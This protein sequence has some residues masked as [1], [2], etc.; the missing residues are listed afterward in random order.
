MN[1]L[2]RRIS[3]GA[4]QFTRPG[5]DRC[6]LP[7]A[8][9]HDERFG[10][11]FPL[12]GG[13]PHPV[14]P[15]GLVQCRKCAL[16]RALVFACRS[17]QSSESDGLMFGDGLENVQATSQAADRLDCDADLPLNSI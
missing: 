13:R 11:E 3:E 8:A 12:R 1:G 4:E 2:P 17:A 15:P 10:C 7:N 5:G 16:Q 6:R 14:N 9:K